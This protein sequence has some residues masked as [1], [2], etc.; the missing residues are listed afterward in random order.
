MA[1]T[2]K[3]LGQASATAAAAPKVVNLIKDPGF[4]N[5]QA[6][7]GFN[8]TSYGNWY[9]MPGTMWFTH[10]V[11]NSSY[12]PYVSLWSGKD[13]GKDAPYADTGGYTKVGGNYN[14]ANRYGKNSLILQAQGDGFS[15]YLGYGF[16]YGLSTGRSNAVGMRTQDSVRFNPYT[17]MPVTGSTTYYFG[18]DYTTYSPTTC[19]YDVLW[20]DNTGHYISASTYDSWQTSTS[21]WTRIGS[22][23]TSP[24][25]AAYAGIE[26]NL[27]FYS[28]WSSQERNA[29]FVDGLY[30]SAEAD[31]ATA[32]PDPS[33][34][35]DNR[36]T[37]PFT[38]RLSAAWSGTPSS[39]T[40]V[41]TY[42]GAQVDL[43][44]VP[45]STQAIISTIAIA[46]A[47]TTGQT[48]R[49][50]VIPSGQ[51]QAA[52]HFVAFD[53]PVSANSTDTYTV[54]MTLAAGDKIR[55]SSD[56][57]QVSF[58]AFGSEIA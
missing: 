34:P 1:T 53:V 23:A 50:S 55:V 46:N 14:T 8:Y 57:A 11:Q 49:I 45:T 21:N 40:T 13:W 6:P 41:K 32:F 22:S 38:D 16:S 7:T 12:Y 20:F 51:T 43:Y 15:G 30:F 19:Y 17:A 28:R 47:S 48:Y 3:V 44:T 36:L 42:A 25:N 10:P 2:Y 9:N 27:G 52:K 24:S 29:F 31:A 56:S 39:S 37:A 35:T 54:G 4:E 33:N 58:T 5:F 18:L 26:L